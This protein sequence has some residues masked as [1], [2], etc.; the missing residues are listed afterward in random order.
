MIPKPFQKLID[1][2]S[3]LPS[4]GPK[5]AE[6]LVLFLFRQ[7]KEKLEDFSENISN[8]KNLKICKKCFNISESDLCEICKNPGREQKTICVVEDALDVISIEKTGIYKGLYHILGGT[9]EPSSGNEK[10]DLKIPQLLDRVKNEK[11]QEI[12]I[13]FNPTAEGDLTA[14][15]LK[16][17]LQPLKIK[18]TR[19]G[20]GLSTG[21][22]IE[23]SDET[24]LSSALTNRKELI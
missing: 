18:I 1:N 7:D 8:L 13:A 23:Y 19:L 17:K 20:R 2:F 6:R 4:V 9:I 24:T 12:I 22:D 5:M 15:Y 3:S 21:G 11:I 10:S 14:L 16:R